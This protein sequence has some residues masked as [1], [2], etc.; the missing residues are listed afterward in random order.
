[1]EHEPNG[2]SFDGDAQVYKMPSQTRG[3]IDG[4]YRSEARDSIEH[5]PAIPPHRG[6]IPTLN[7]LKTRYGSQLSIVALNNYA[8]GSVCVNQ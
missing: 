4:R 2:D 5:A 3:V 1:M 7:T 8:L 6:P